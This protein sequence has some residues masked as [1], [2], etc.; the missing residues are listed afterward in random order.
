MSRHWR[1][2]ALQLVILSAMGFVAATD[3]GAYVSA[4]S[5]AVLVL[6]T[7]NW[8]VAL[9][10]IWASRQDDT[11]RSL[12]DAADNALTWAIN[13]SVAGMIGI[14]LLGLQAGFLRG[15]FGVLITVLLGFIIVT[16]SLPAVRFLRT[17]RD[18]WM[19]MIRERRD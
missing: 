10:L 13:S 7:I 15:Q 1:N 14:I 8:T 9:L 19:P 18:V 16:G 11:I 4:V 2:I 6:P 12:A 17:W 5:V 3:M